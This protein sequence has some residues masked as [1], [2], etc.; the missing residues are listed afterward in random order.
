MAAMS[1]SS[2]LHINLASPS[3][4]PSGPSPLMTP[5]F[6]PNTPGVNGGAKRSTYHHNGS[7]EED[8][9]PDLDL[10]LP[11]STLLKLGTQRA[12]VKA[13]HSAGAAALVQGGLELEEYIR[14]L[15]VLWR[16]YDA[17]ELGLAENSSN[18]VLAPTYDPALLARAPA[19][20][21]DITYLLSL[22]PST[23]T[24]TTSP[25]TNLT[26]SST[27]LPPFPLPSFLETVFTSPP[28]PLQTY[29]SHVKSLSASSGS[30][31][32]LLAHAYV[33]YLGDLSGGQF[34]GARV[35]K[36]YGLKSPDESGAKFYHF[37]FDNS[38]TAATEDGDGASRADVKKRLGEVKDWY[39]RGMD[40]GVG[41]DKGLKS[42]LVHEANLAFSYNTDLFSV[43]NITP[44]HSQSNG[45]IAVDHHKTSASA[46]A[47]AVAA[48]APS[49]KIRD[50]ISQAL[51]LFVAAGVG[52]L[53]NIYAG[54][55][56]Q[57]WL[58][59]QGYVN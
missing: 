15:A 23:S 57:S 46:P 14:W 11:I 50:T 58:K 26:T 2:Q 34:I 55:V 31:S 3:L 9:I 49:S 44:K 5:S 30:A 7:A 28:E 43:I 29:L 13:E 51:W 8:G 33:R 54:P 36:S 25:T 24:S 40:E 45:K 39:R 19:L 16:I 52:V 12:H 10:N 20:A 41:E 32:K 38:R 22:L 47:Q 17:L 27:P 53:L 56:L 4:S 1:S 48:L 42:D 21:D 18:P 35:K 37:D 6:Q 59:S